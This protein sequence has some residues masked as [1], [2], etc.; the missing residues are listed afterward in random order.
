M[1]TK[2]LT[3]GILALSILGTTAFATPQ[4]PVATDNA[5]DL[6]TIASYEQDLLTIASAGALT[7]ES[8]GVY[9]LNSTEMDEVHGGLR[10]K[11]GKAKL[12]IKKVCIASFICIIK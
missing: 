12:T 11:I 4:A 8:A 1:A 2:K 7:S 5:Q 9:Q 6:P 10:I 3:A